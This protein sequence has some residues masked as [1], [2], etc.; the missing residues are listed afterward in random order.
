MGAYTLAF[1]TALVLGPT[2]GTAVFQA[3]GGDALWLAA[4][5]LAMVLAVAFRL[6]APHLDREAEAAPDRS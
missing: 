3:F 6:L 5:A 1:S 4:G 2:T